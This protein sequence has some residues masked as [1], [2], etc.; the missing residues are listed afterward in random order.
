[1]ARQLSLLPCIDVEA[2]LL[3]KKI[4][5]MLQVLQLQACFIV[6]AGARF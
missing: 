1:M 2:N 6:S 5:L 3:A 4:D